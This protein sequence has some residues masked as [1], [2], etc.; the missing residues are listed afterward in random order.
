MG[1]SILRLVEPNQGQ[2]LFKGQ[3]LLGLSGSALRGLRRELAIIFQ[4]PFASLDPRQT[5]GEI[6]A[7]P[8]DI[9]RLSAT[10]QERRERV[11]ELFQAVGL[12]PNLANRYPHEF[13]GGQR[14]RV[15]IARALAVDPSFIVCDEPVS[16]L[17]VSIQAQIVNLLERLQEQFKLTYLFIAHDLSLVRHIA[18]RIAVMYLGKVVE[19]ASASEL[20]RRARHP[21]TVSLLSAI[22]I[23]D[24]RIERGRRRIILEGDVRRRAAASGPGASGPRIGA[25]RRSLPWR[26]S[27]STATRPPAS[28]RSSD[29]GAEVGGSTPP[30]PTK[31]EGDEE[32]PAGR[33]KLRLGVR[34]RGSRLGPAA[35]RTR[36]RSR[37]PGCDG[38]CSRWCRSQWRPPGQAA[39]SNVECPEHHDQGPGSQWSAAAPRRVPRSGHIGRA[40]VVPET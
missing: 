8:L 40:I 29:G 13:S 2:V 11:E 6:V 33:R 20:H 5:V 34:P 17:D 7:E 19:L 36:R 1:R 14:Q 18:D 32:E 21:Y 15:G 25:P 27:S 30:R 9:H 37:R 10:R 38:R 26:P 23:P 4:D 28:S 24:P 31:L 12:N 35:R 22:P 39:G 3:D 16:A